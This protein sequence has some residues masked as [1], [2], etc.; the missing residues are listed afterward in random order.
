MGMWHN[1]KSSWQC[2]LYLAPDPS[3]YMQSFPLARRTSLVLSKGCFLVVR[4]MLDNLSDEFLLETTF[5]TLIFIL[6]VFP[7]ISKYGITERNRIYCRREGGFYFSPFYSSPYTF[8]NSLSG[9][10]FIVSLCKQIQDTFLP[11]LSCSMESGNCCQHHTSHFILLTCNFAPLFS[12]LCFW[13]WNWSLVF[14]DRGYLKGILKSQWLCTHHLRCNW[15]LTSHCWTN[16]SPVG[17]LRVFVSPLNLF[18][19]RLSSKTG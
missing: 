10:N 9:L 19:V 8:K 5:L 2:L 15:Q 12:E 14:V 4:N 6:C 3:I 1:E 18:F 16:F 11:R 13:E 7:V 17:A